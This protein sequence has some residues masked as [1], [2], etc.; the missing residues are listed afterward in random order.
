MRMEVTPRAA[1][2]PSDQSNSIEPGDNVNMVMVW[3]TLNR[4]RPVQ[5][6]HTVIVDVADNH[7]RGAEFPTA[8][9]TISV[10]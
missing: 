4:K 9:G 5:V 1:L 6:Y 7:I 2:A 8:L 3:S 10:R